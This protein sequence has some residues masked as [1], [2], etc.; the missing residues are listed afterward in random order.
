MAYPD[1]TLTFSRMTQALEQVEAKLKEEYGLSFARL[2]KLG[3]G[4]PP[5]LTIA[6]EV[7]KL[8]F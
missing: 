7:D 3:C 4:F 1:L 2:P 8:G 6:Y 5:N